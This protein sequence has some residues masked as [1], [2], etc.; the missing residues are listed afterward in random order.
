MLTHNTLTTYR[1]VLSTCVAFNYKTYG[2][3]M[4]FLEIQFLEVGAGNSISR[5]LYRMTVVREACLVHT[6]LGNHGNHLPTHLQRGIF[7]I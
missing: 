1:V 3:E 7:F 5:R 6:F 4:P 2:I